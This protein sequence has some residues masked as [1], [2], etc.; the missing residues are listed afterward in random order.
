V[1]A[2]VFGVL[3]A[4]C[5]AD[6]ALASGWWDIGAT[7]LAGAWVG[8]AMWL[9]DSP[10]EHIERVRRGAE[11]ER[12]TAREL[13]RLD[14]RDWTVVHDIEGLFGNWDHVVVGQGGVF[15]LD[16]KNLF[17]EAKLEDGCLVVRRAETPDELSRFD[18]LGPRKRGA[19]A[20]L[21]DALRDDRGRP[22][23]TP[24]VVVWP[25]LAPPATEARG[26]A[27]RHVTEWLRE[28]EPVLGQQR[29]LKLGERLTALAEDTATRPAGPW[30]REAT[31]RR[32]RA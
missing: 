32:E 16:P 23:V 30:T 22:W 28:R 6:G 31:V 10:P 29:C 1:F 17:G 12:K 7:F 26:V 25:E 11:G 21:S 5:A 15:L 20:G 14:L 27:G 9:W 8:V 4:P 13:K 19:A 2:A 3:I 18:R 24:V